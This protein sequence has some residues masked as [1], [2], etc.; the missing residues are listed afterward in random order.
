MPEPKLYR[1]PNG[2][3]GMM[4]MARFCDRCKHDAKFRETEDGADA[5]QI[6]TKTLFLDTDDPGYP[7]EWIYDRMPPLLCNARCTAF[8]EESSDA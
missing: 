6:A 8:E 2:T 5:C 7:R 3:E 1:P 4:F